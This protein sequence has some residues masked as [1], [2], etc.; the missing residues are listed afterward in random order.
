MSVEFPKKMDVDEL[1]WGEL[2]LVKPRAILGNQLIDIVGIFN[3]VIRDFNVKLSFSI[4]YDKNTVTHI[5]PS[6]VWVRKSGLKKI[7]PRDGFI[8]DFHSS[9]S[10]IRY[11]IYSLRDVETKIK[12]KYEQGEVIT[13]SDLVTINPP[14]YKEELLAKHNSKIPSL[15]TSAPQS[16]ST[17]ETEYVGEQGLG[18]YN[19]RV[20]KSHLGGKSKRKNKKTRK[21]NKNKKRHKSNK[22]KKSNTTHRKL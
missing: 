12:D 7:Y 11:D 9:G 14:P 4:M 21:S 16:L 10:S 2:Y 6:Q 1:E 20:S 19:P 22:N 15:S 8:R 13:D 3:G 18:S 17:K 5:N